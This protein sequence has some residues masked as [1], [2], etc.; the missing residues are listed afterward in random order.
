MEK[1]NF[2]TV[3]KLLPFTEADRADLANRYIA[4]EDGKKID[5]L[6]ELYTVFYDYKLGLE[7]LEYQNLLDEVKQGQNK[8]SNQLMKDA[9]ERVRGYFN[10]ILIGKVEDRVQIDE[11]RE[12]LKA[13]SG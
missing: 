6:H 7:E 4:L 10:N 1:L 5:F 9:R 2:E 11:I 13:F 8:L 12:K 3:I